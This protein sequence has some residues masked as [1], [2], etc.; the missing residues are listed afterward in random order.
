V[1]A[2]TFFVY[3]AYSTTAEKGSAEGDVGEDESAGK[4]LG[5]RGRTDGQVGCA[6]DGPRCKRRGRVD[7]QDRVVHHVDIG[8][9][10]RNLGL[11]GIGDLVPATG[12]GGDFA[13]G[14]QE[15]AGMEAN[16]A[17]RPVD[18]VTDTV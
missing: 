14:K 10:V 11:D 4:N 1:V 12:A 3:V 9:F 16:F 7:G 2:N 5:R 15:F 13:I 8:L 6:E 18:G 17:A